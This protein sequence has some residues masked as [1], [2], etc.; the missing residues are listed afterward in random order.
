MRLR[1][2][3]AEIAR[4]APAVRRKISNVHILAHLQYAAD[5]R[6]EGAIAAKVREWAFAACEIDYIRFSPLSVS[7]FSL[8][9]AAF[10]GGDDEEMQ[11]KK[12]WY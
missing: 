6:L 1:S 8:F 10:R 7:N 5:R 9:F 12:P 3:I 4:N 2:G 11:R